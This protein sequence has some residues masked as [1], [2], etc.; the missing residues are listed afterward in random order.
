MAGVPAAQRNDGIRAASVNERKAGRSRRDRRC[1][2]PRRARRNTKIGRIDL[3]TDETWIIEVDMAEHLEIRALYDRDTITVYQAYKKE[4][5]EAAVKNNRFVAPFSFNRMTWIKPSFLWMMERSNWGKK[6]G[7]EYILSVKIKRECFEKALSM[8][9]L[10]NPD[11]TVYKQ[12]DE[13]E[14]LFEEAKIHIQWDP[15]RDINGNK[16]GY[17]SIQIGISRYLIKEYNDE[18]IVEINDISP[19]VKKIDALIRS[20]NKVKAKQFLPN[21]KIY[22][23]STEIKKK[24]GMKS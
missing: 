16:L 4:I 5:A 24:L 11:K 22:P 18:W 10:T 14:K 19:L 17:R 9:V 15:E 1:L 12:F 8:G 20:G 13:W 3:A 7:Q 23:L 2:S 6:S 21:E